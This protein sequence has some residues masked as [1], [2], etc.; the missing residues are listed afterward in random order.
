MQIMN[1]TGTARQHWRG[2][3]SAQKCCCFYQGRR[4]CPPLGERRD[5]P[6]IAT[7]FFIRVQMSSHPTQ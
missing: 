5:H 3:G 4:I 2:F 7:R 6:H 1:R